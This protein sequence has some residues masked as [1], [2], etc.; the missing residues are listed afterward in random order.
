MYIELTT[1]TTCFFI[2]NNLVLRIGCL[3][4]FDLPIVQLAY[5]MRLISK[6][7]DF[8]GHKDYYTK[9]VVGVYATNTLLKIQYL[10]DYCS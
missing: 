9:F 3:Q 1:S 10:A 6:N 8:E 7:I 4:E 5:D 2:Q